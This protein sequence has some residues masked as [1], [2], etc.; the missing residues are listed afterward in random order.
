MWAV[1]LKAVG[2]MT[3]EDNADAKICTKC[4]RIV[5]NDTLVCSDCGGIIFES[6]D[7]GGRD[8]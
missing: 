6:V 5:P 7:F 8:E 2:E 1:Q 3:G 4:G